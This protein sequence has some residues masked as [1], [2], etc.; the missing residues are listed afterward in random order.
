MWFLR[1]FLLLAK[2]AKCWLVVQKAAT[3]LGDTNGLFA[4]VGKSP[5]S[6]KTAKSLFF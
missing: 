1:K 2:N 4:K 5:T 6:R 3:L